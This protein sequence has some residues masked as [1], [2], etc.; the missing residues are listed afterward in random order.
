MAQ[1]R[2]YC[3]AYQAARQVRGVI[4]CPYTKH[5]CPFGLHQCKSCGRSGHGAEDCWNTFQSTD[6]A[7]P[8]PP[9]PPAPPAPTPESSCSNPKKPRQEEGSNQAVFVPGFGLKGE[10]KLANYGV[11]IPGPVVVP[12]EEAASTQHSASSSGLPAPQTP[13]GGPKIPPPI[14]ATTEDV[15]AWV[16]GSFKPLSNISQNI[17]PQL[18][19]S[20]LWR[21]V[22]TG[23][24]GAPSTTCEYF[25]GK[26]RSLAV[27]DDE[28]YVYLD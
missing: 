8:P 15:E 28:V 5:T 1:R 16:T 12:K 24:S 11:E 14:Q 10:G 2:Q 18:G 4:M 7:P 9:A 25:N 19:E 23:K 3:D 21:G 27:E 6:L 22:K 26:V 17:P 13:P 20:V